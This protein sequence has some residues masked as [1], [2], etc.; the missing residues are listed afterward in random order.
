MTEI[1]QIYD[2][3]NRYITSNEGLNFVNFPYFGDPNIIYNISNLLYSSIIIDDVIIVK[4]YYIYIINNN[5]LNI[6]TIYIVDNEL[7]PPSGPL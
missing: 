6:W 4:N 1:F 2:Y 3:I 5:D 7:V